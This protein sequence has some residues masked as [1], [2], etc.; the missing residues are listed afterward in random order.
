[1]LSYTR[2][3]FLLLFC[4]V[5]LKVN[6]QLHINEMMAVNDATI[7][8]GM[9]EYDD[10]IEI[11]NGG[12]TIDLAGYYIT[13]DP[14]DLLKWQ[15]PN[16]NS[17]ITS[18]PANGYLILW[19]DQDLAQGEDHLDFKLSSNGETV[20]LISPDG[21]TLVDSMSFSSLTQDHSFG[22]EI[23]GGNDKRTFSTSS[24]FASNSTGVS[25]VAE[26]QFSISGGLYSSSQNI[27]LST[28]TN[29]STIRYTTDGSE[30]DS[31]SPI[32]NSAITINDV[33]TIRAK[34]FKSGW[35]SSLTTS[36]SYL[37]GV[38]HSMAIVTIN[39]NP[40]NLWDDQIGIHVEGTNGISG[41]CS[42]PP[43]NWNQPWERPAN[44]Q[45]YD[46]N[47]N[48]GFNIDAGISISGG[49]SRRFDQKSFNVETKSIYP[50]E[51]I[52]YQLFP[53]RDQH[54]F[55]RFKLRAG[56]NEWYI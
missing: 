13:D 48:F 27:Q 42:A 14:L 39:T 51:N 55:R 17:S 30:P 50:S 20:L 47:G 4:V 12:P 16:T 45:F 53:D 10:W 41:N 1:M 24:P 32:Y 8:D 6:A 2:I 52:P 43:V 34:A 44:I 56:G 15:I 5:A 29:A 31:T 26:V 40:D 25:Q 21:T 11:Y 3:G 37:V 36:E 9:G 23:D 28:S 49:C 33:N 54:E 18:I 35:D 46:E 38:S 7:A 22:R 19:A